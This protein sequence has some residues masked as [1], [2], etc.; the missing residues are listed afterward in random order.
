MQNSKVIFFFGMEHMKHTFSTLPQNKW[1]GRHTQRCTSLLF[2]GMPISFVIA[3]R[4]TINSVCKSLH[5]NNNNNEI[6][7]LWIILCPTWHWDFN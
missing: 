4:D 2:K 7:L 5:N 1:I 3:F 6:V